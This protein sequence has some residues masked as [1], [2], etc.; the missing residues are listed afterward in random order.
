MTDVPVTVPGPGL[1][2]RLGEPVTAQLSVLGWPA[3]TVAG[4]ALKLVMVGALP[5]I[6]VTLAA[7]DPK[8]LVAVRV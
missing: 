8:L 1:M 7:V 6:T 3:V 4:V 5:A 2:T